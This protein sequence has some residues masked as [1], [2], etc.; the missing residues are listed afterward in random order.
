[1]E[2]RVA[3]VVVVKQAVRGRRAARVRRVF[4]AWLLKPPALVLSWFRGI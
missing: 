3:V 4:S 1:M 2:V